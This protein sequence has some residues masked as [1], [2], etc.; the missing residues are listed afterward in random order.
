VP[1]AYTIA[2]SPCAPRPT[3]PV[4]RGL[5]TRPRLHYGLLTQH[6]VGM[7]QVLYMTAQR[8]GSA[9]PAPVNV[10]GRDAHGSGPETKLVMQVPYDSAQTLALVPSEAAAN[11]AMD[12]DFFKDDDIKLYYAGDFCSRRLP[13]VEAA[14]LSAVCATCRMRVCNTRATRLMCVQRMCHSSVPCSCACQSSSPVISAKLPK[15]S[16]EG[17]VCMRN[18]RE[19]RAC[20]GTPRLRQSAGAFCAHSRSGKRVRVTLTY[21]LLTYVL[22]ILMYHAA[23]EQKHAALH[24]AAVLG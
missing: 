16:C 4:P 11:T 6:L 23:C 9:M 3:D 7:R 1:L 24:M 12:D 14:A 13:G 19:Q 18:A 10:G 21:V 20:T 8:W 5:L 22:L 2:Y 17:G 15:R